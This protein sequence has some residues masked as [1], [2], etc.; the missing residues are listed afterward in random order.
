MTI[1]VKVIIR[2]E[3]KIKAKKF[4]IREPL[5]LIKV[6]RRSLTSILFAILRKFQ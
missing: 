1:R 5:F 2:I 6:P 4:S 3:L